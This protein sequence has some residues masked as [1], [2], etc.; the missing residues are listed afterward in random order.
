M[1]DE[2]IKKL[3]ETQN[4]VLNAVSAKPNNQHSNI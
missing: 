1:K 3:V 2:I 4:T